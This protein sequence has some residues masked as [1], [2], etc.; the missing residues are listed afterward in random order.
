MVSS[1]FSEIGSL[2]NVE[3]NGQVSDWRDHKNLLLKNDDEKMK[4]G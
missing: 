4:G 3:S 2:A 1:A